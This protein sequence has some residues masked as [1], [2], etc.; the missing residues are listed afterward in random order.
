M[1]AILFILGIVLFISLVVVHEWGH[2]IVA[3]RGGVEVDEFGIGFPPRVWSKKV[4]TKKSKFLFTINL[5]PLGG[6]VRLKGESDDATAKGSY[7]AA[8]LSVKIKIM[9]AGVGM[10]LV[11]A[12]GLLTIVA[13]IGTP[14][15][16]PN[17]FTVANDTNITREVE[18][19]GL[20]TIAK[21]G[22][23]TPAYKAGLKENDQILA[24]AGQTIDRAEK[25]GE[26]ISRNAGKTV[27]IQVK[28]D[29][30][31]QNLTASL[32]AQNDGSGLLGI[33]SQSGEEGIQLRQ[34]TWSAPVVAG[35]MIAQFTGLTFEGLG[36]VFSSL[37]EGDTKSASEQVTGP[38]GIFKIMEAGSKVGINFVLM[39]TAI[40]SLSL[41]IMNILP[42]PA[43]DGGR[44]FVTLLFR[45]IKKPLTKSREEW[46]HG[47][48]FV[49]LILL[50]ILISV[51]DYKR[52][53]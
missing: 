45:A 53:F 44:L 40:I 26:I 11:V 42:I 18:N 12:F 22:E 47:T 9:L 23:N 28:R 31:Q 39:L 41:A 50:M 17:Q 4:R 32:N 48:G 46:I 13:L 35:G 38:I 33:S 6:F 7:G 49:V 51:V 19:K 3:R 27:E 16:V 25:V 52:F 8:P 21:V 14:T 24:I 37:S 43:L 29:G 1:S 2:F 34:S 15:L 36:K 30:R 5:L 20:V 10:N